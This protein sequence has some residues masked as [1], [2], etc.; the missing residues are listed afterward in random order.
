M[1][2]TFHVYILANVRGTRPVLYIGVTGNLAHRLEEH[3][4]APTGFVRLYRTTTLVF[5]EEFGDPA[6]AIARETQLKG[7]LRRRKIALIK[8]SNPE[9]KDL[10]AT[11]PNPVCPGGS[12]LRS[13]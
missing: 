1:T 8:E 11:D 10:I 7:W 13:E 4:Q 6:S 9:W 12:S 3:R 5:V 2:R